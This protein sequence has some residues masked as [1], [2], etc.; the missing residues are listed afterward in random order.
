MSGRRFVVPLALNYRPP[1]PRLVQQ[2]LETRLKTDT[3]DTFYRRAFAGLDRD[4]VQVIY[5]TLGEFAGRVIA[6]VFA[7]DTFTERVHINQ[8]FYR[9]TGTSRDIGFEGMWF[10]MD[11]FD[12]DPFSREGYRIKKLEDYYLSEPQHLDEYVQGNKQNPADDIDA[13]GRYLRRDLAVVGAW[14]RSNWM[15]PAALGVVDPK[16]LVVA[17][18]SVLRLS[19]RR[20]MDVQY[21]LDMFLPP[22]TRYTQTDTEIEITFGTHLEMMDYYDEAKLS[23]VFNQTMLGIKKVLFL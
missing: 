17:Q 10:P 8:L 19:F 22:E 12:P 23:D 6:Y 4:V 16:V 1:A 13:Y 2:H 9:S 15:R 20:S 3:Y 18:T 21:Y 14:L 11:Q 7:Y 5:K